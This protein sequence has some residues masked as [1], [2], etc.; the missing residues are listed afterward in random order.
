MGKFRFDDDPLSSPGGFGPS[1]ATIRVRQGPVRTTLIKPVNNLNPLNQLN[2]ECKRFFH[3]WM[4]SLNVLWRKGP[5]PNNLTTRESKLT[6]I[7]TYHI[8]FI[9]EFLAKAL[10]WENCVSTIGVAYETAVKGHRDALNKADKGSTALSLSAMW[11][12]V[13][14]LATGGVSFCFGK[15]LATTAQSVSKDMS[16]AATSALGNVGPPLSAI[17]SDDPPDGVKM[18][19]RAYMEQ[20]TRWINGIKQDMLRF[21]GKLSVKLDHMTEAEWQDYDVDQHRIRLAQALDRADD[22]H[23]MKKV[24]EQTIKEMAETLE[25]SFWAEWVLKVCSQANGYKTVPG[26]VADRLDALG[27]LK[28]AGTTISGFWNTLGDVPV[29]GIVSAAVGHTSTQEDQK[30]LA[31]AKK[32]KAIFDKSAWAKLAA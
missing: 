20:V 19:P 9:S 4:K 13:S 3:L 7:N 6:W 27:I 10:S 18:E 11:S 32:F 22:L 23:G 17:F 29:I 8:D 25:K 31:W 2:K 16:T 14:V 5:P 12:A 24:P 21:L 1:D 15:D 30:L 26:A 28:E